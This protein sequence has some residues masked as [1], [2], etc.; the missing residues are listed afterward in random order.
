MWKLCKVISCFLF[1]KHD[2]KHHGGK[3]VLSLSIFEVILPV[4]CYIFSMFQH[5]E[6]QNLSKVVIWPK[7]A[8]W[9]LKYST[10]FTRCLFSPNMKPAI[11]LLQCK[12]IAMI[13][14]VL[15][16]RVVWEKSRGV[17]FALLGWTGG[18][19]VAALLCC[20]YMETWL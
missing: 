10:S 5:S 3:Y 1:W 6:W 13:H 19:L 2:S 12:R 18:R 17:C 14:G 15:E 20:D 8:A 11:I 4:L 16:D 7:T 9:W